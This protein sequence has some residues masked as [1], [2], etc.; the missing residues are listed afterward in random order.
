MLRERSK[1]QGINSW[2]FLKDGRK[3]EV[4]E[5]ALKGEMNRRNECYK[6]CIKAF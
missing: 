6:I 1:E 2:K 3:K 4:R 5:R